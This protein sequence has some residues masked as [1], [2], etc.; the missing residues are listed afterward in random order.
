MAAVGVFHF[1]SAQTSRIDSTPAVAA[2]LA[3]KN[4]QIRALQQ[5]RARLT[6][7]T[8]RLRE[9]V[10]DLK[11]N[12]DANAAIDARVQFREYRLPEAIAPQPPPEKWMA[13]AVAEGA[14]EALPRLEA[15]A[16]RND[17]YA[18]EALALMADSDAAES[19]TRVWKS[20]RLN[21][22]NRLKAARYLAATMEVNPEAEELLEGLFTN[23]ASDGRV[24]DAVLDGLV[25]PSFPVT[26]ARAETIP[27]PPHFRPEFGLRQAW[28]ERMIGSVEDERA[29]AYLLRAREE[30]QVRWAEAEP[31]AE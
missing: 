31:P 28:L 15:L 29:R 17:A 9:T 24:L 11:S 3:A 14:V 6:A 12:L 7:E 8:Q 4:E 26:L 22:T 25:N 21:F 23:P 10:S 19:L 16:L 20:G 30:L 1:V 27:P 18:L 2:E 13:E 5:D